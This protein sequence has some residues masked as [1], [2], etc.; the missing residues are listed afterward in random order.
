MSSSF[1][2]DLV[3]DASLQ[4]NALD[5]VGTSGNLD[6]DPETEEAFSPIDVWVLSDESAV[7]AFKAVETITE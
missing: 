5:I 3:H 6:Y 4:Q 7:W 2:I 1:E